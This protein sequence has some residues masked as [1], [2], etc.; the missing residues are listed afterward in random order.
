VAVVCFTV[1][2]ALLVAWICWSRSRIFYADHKSGSRSDAPSDFEKAWAE[3][4]E[5][6][7][8]VLIQV[9]R[10][11]IANPRQQPLVANLIRRGLLRL[12]PDLQACSD[13]FQQFIRK[14][15]K[16]LANELASWERVHTDQRWRHF[17]NGFVAVVGGLAF[18]LIATQPGLQSNLVGIATGLT[19]MLA[20]G[21]KLRD[22]IAPWFARGKASS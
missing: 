16:V 5:D 20:T 17:R 9:T 14:Q 11:G 10:E 6:E 12:D 21:A 2:L 19:G 4:G 13:A 15:E 22:A 1:V 7:R 8:H 18:F 3:C